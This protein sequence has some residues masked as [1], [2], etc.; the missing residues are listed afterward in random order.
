MSDYLLLKNKS[1]CPKCRCKQ[2]RSHNG[3]CVNCGI[4]L[5]VRE[6]NFDAYEAD[7]NS[8]E[9]WF[10]NPE[11]GWMHRSQIMISETPLERKVAELVT[12]KN[13]KTAERR[14]AEVKAE[15]KEKVKAI[16]PKLNQVGYG[17]SVTRL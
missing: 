16:T 3:H 1:E 6:I 5:F 11:K 9:W 7:G 4:K 14:V 17:K 8:R 13:T 12:E 15:T 10:F 2:N